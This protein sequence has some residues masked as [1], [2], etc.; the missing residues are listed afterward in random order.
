MYVCFYVCI[1]CVHICKVSIYL[2]IWNWKK[3]IYIIHYTLFNDYSMSWTSVDLLMWQPYLAYLELRFFGIRIW[4]T[5]VLFQDSF[6]SNGRDNPSRET[7][8]IEMGTRLPASNSDMGMEAFN[9][10]VL[11]E[12]FWAYIKY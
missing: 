8:D 9:T 11:L 3:E 1:I 6:V 7:T 2:C 4:H 5:V 10:Q 12:F